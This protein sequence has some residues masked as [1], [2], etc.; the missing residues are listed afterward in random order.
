LLT[1]IYS[2]GESISQDSCGDWEPFKEEKCFK[3]FEKVGLQSYEEASKICKD[4]DSSLVSIRSQEE[5]QFLTNLLFSKSK[6]VENVW[7][8]AKYINNKF[9]WGDESELT[10]T[11][12]A[13]GSPKNRT[14]YCVQMHSDEDSVGK[15]VDEPC[16]KKNVV[17]C[18]KMKSI[19]VSRLHELFLDLKKNL[20][21]IGFIYVQLPKEKSPTSIWSWMTWKD[22]TS[23]YA[24][25]FFR[26]EGG[27]AATFGQVQ[28]DNAPRLVEVNTQLIRFIKSNQTNWWNNTIP[29]GGWSNWVFN[30]GNSGEEVDMRF[31][32]SGGEVRPRNM[33]IRVWKRAG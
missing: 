6:L 11:N 27:E 16:M 23:D 32:V 8:G 10:F 19:S 21:P 14:D 33:A 31:Q 3:I 20:I 13:P 9:K 30:G 4:N 5:Q 7:I 17:L 15:W 26:A 2:L 12:W 24:G 22:V 29:R 1:H 18:Q 28:Q 25:L